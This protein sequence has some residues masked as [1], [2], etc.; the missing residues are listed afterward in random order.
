MRMPAYLSRSRHGIF[1]YRYP[2][3]RPLHPKRATTAIRLSLGTRDRREALLMAHSLSYVASL[4]GWHGAQNQMDYAEFRSILSAH[5]K[6]VLEAQKQSIREN[7]HLSPLV[8]YSFQ[9]AVA[10]A[11]V[12]HAETFN[13]AAD[14]DAVDNFWIDQ[15]LEGFGR[16][17]EMPEE[18]RRMLRNE[19]RR[20]NGAYCQAVLDFDSAFGSY[21][22]GSDNQATASLPP[23][24][25]S[26]DFTS[27]SQLVT[28]F[29][30]YTALEERW[31]PKTE[32]EKQEHIDLL[33]EVLGKDLDARTV[34][35][36]KARRVREV[37]ASYPV[38]RNKG[39]LTRGKTLGEILG[40]TGLK[41]LHRLTINK[42]LQTYKGL[43]NWAKQNGYCAENPFSGLSLG[44]KRGNDEAPR[45]PF[46]SS[47]LGTLRNALL[48]K[49]RNLQEHHKWGT[50]I[51][52]H[53]GARLNEVAQ[54]H[55]DDIRVIDGIH[56]FDINGSGPTKKLKNAS[57][58]RV[59]PI[60]PRLIEYGLLEYIDAVRAKPGN[61]R[62][63]PQL[64]YTA[65]DGYGRNLGRWFN[66]TFLPDMNLK[67]RQLTFHSL[68]HSVVNQLIKA[69]VSQ[70]HIMAIVGHEP[71]TTTLS[72]YNRNGF[73]PAQLLA[74]LEKV[75]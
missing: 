16:P 65:S 34:D 56:C 9:Q 14:A 22:F 50:L 3:P 27:L 13:Q 68:R 28:E 66:E 36:P 49:G 7:G 69:D 41:T 48:D 67:T 2:I 74:A 47:E 73:P 24:Q 1:Y 29:W 31:T 54:L 20:A 19:Y 58:K 10:G 18:T 21:D 12:P 5:F 43:F 61:E 26:S 38:N 33:Y 35:H 72:T 55:L 23:S 40:M 53:S 17:T 70:P 75:F 63:F 42:Y 52:M 15:I 39:K 59:V 62:L 4:V 60:H 44:N 46:S 51:A 32:G 30:K 45:L 11:R 64:T 8:V 57:S 25:K 71:G 6:S 37:L